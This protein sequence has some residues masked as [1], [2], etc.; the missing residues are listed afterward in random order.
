LFDIVGAVLVSA[1]V[2]ILLATAL[3]LERIVVPMSIDDIGG[4]ETVASANAASE[5][6]A[7]ERIPA[8]Q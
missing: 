2:R 5:L 4:Q 1:G 7:G 6:V 3:F 8:A